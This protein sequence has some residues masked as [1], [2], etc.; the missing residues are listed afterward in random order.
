MGNSTRLRPTASASSSGVYSGPV[1]SGMITPASAMKITVITPSTAR[2][3]P[4]SAP[5]RLNASRF[6][7]FSSSSVKTGTKAADSAASANRLR[8][9]LGTWKASVNAEAGPVVPK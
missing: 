3:S 1:N 4:N 9:R 5:A 7:P 6:S 2:I 8:T